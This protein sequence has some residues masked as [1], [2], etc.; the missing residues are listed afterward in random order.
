MSLADTI[1]Q[2]L[3]NPSSPVSPDWVDKMAERHP[4][5]IF[6]GALLV[7]RNPGA[8]DAEKLRDLKLHLLLN[9]SDTEALSEMVDISGDD[10]ANLYPRIAQEQPPTTESAIATFLDA[11]GCSSDNETSTLE[12]LIFN[13]APA[14]YFSE[15]ELGEGAGENGIPVLPP[16]LGRALSP[17]TEETV[18][19]T[20]ESDNN[21]TNVTIEPSPVP[22]P[23]GEQK[24]APTD[25]EKIAPKADD[26]LLSE[27]LAKIFIKQGRYERAFEIITNL[28]LNFPKKSVYFADQL[29]F[30]QLLIKNQ[31][32]Q[33]QNK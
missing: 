20:V 23:A 21:A 28:S 4:A 26:S 22:E 5:F 17:L 13:P 7:K 6:P 15:E 3:D 25:E 12:Q 8:V 19:Q 30:L 31:H 1:L 24:E 27:S 33:Q 16:E 11:Y 14:D 2:L 18:D 29:R 32:Y 10:F 9:V